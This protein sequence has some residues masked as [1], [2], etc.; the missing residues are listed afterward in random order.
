MTEKVIYV[1]IIPEIR[2]VINSA[3]EYEIFALMYALDERGNKIYFSNGYLAR[4]LG[5]STRAISKIISKLEA[6]GLI[7]RLLQGSNRVIEIVKEK[8]NLLLGGTKVPTPRTFVPNKTT[9][10]SSN[11]NIVVNNIINERENIAP[12]LLNLEIFFKEITKEFDVD[13]KL[14]A[15]K[16]FLKKTKYI[17]WKKERSSWQDIA[18]AYWLSWKDNLGDKLNKINNDL[19]VYK[20]KKIEEK[21]IA[22]YNEDI[23]RQ[24]DD[25]YSNALHNALKYCLKSYSPKQI[26][27]EINKIKPRPADFVYNLYLSKDKTPDTLKTDYCVQQA[28]IKKLPK[29]YQNIKNYYE[30]YNLKIGESRIN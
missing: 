9:N 20:A 5:K 29:R 10:K 1:P 2:R 13:Y 24:N 7:R 18:E 8:I 19:L 25:I 15:K 4:M 28:F 26:D 11:N 21:K 16:C 30:Y 22:D 12:I 23:N 27:A 14:I 6:K 17:N 3:S